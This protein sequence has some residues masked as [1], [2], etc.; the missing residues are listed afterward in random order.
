MIAAA[1]SLLVLLQLRPAACAFNLTVVVAHCRQNTAWLSAHAARGVTI[2]LCT[3]RGCDASAFP[4]QPR[5]ELTEN[6]GFEAASYLKYIVEYYDELPEQVAFIHGHESAWHRTATSPSII[7]LAETVAANAISIGGASYVSLNNHYLRP[8]VAAEDK[9]AFAPNGYIVDIWPLLF[10]EYMPRGSKFAATFACPRA[11][12]L[13]CCAQF[14]TTRDAIRA[15]PKEAYVRWLHLFANQ[16]AGPRLMQH[17]PY[18]DNLART[19]EFLWH[20]LF[21]QECDDHLVTTPHLYAEHF[22][23]VRSGGAAGSANATNVTAAAPP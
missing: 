20:V 21:G 23:S 1:L 17:H 19:F 14:V 6:V 4:A 5:C 13:D 3:K 11:I 9:S 22:F 7:A 18:S 16:A 8:S 2:T 10:A 12:H 15:I